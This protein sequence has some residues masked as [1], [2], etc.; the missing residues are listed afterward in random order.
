MVTSNRLTISQKYFKPNYSYYKLQN[1]GCKSGLPVFFAILHKMLDYKIMSIKIDSKHETSVMVQTHC[2]QEN[3]Y[4]VP[5]HLK[6]RW[7]AFLTPKIQDS[8]YESQLPLPPE[9]SEKMIKYPHHIHISN[10]IYM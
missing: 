10:N 1:S 9:F 3:N 6:Q 4:I 7:R 2:L 8:L 5:H